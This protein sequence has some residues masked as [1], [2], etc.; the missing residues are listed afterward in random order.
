MTY[1]TRFSSILN[2]TFN[3]RTQ[4]GVVS[5]FAGVPSILKFILKSDLLAPF[6]KT[7][8]EFASRIKPAYSYDNADMLMML[9]VMYMTGM[10]DFNDA[11]EL[12]C[13][14]LIARF[15]DVP[16]DS[17][18]C[19]FFARID[20]IC[21]NDRDSRLSDADK[22]LDDC[23]KTDSLRICSAFTDKLNNVLLEGAI[24]LLKSNS[25]KHIVIDVDS[26]PVR[27]YGQQNETAFDAHYGVK[28]YL[29]IFVTINGI[30]AFV[31][32]APGAAYGAAL[33]KLHAQTIINRLNE[34]FP[35]AVVIVRADTGYAHQPLI[36]LIQDLGVR[37]IIGCNIRGGAP[38]RQETMKL[39]CD[40]FESRPKD[41]ALPKTLKKYIDAELY[42]PSTDPQAEPVRLCGMLCDYQFKS[43]KFKRNIVFRLNIDPKFDVPNLRY[44]QTNLTK[45][46]ILSFTQGRGCRKQRAL[47][48][49]LFGS[50]T[51]D[52]EF[53]IELYE[54][55]FADRGMDERMNQE[56]KAQCC[57]KRVS[58]SGF[59]A[60]TARM[61]IA[62]LVYQI[63]EKLRRFLLPTIQ[64]LTPTK[65][66]NSIKPNRT[67]PHKAEKIL[68]GPTI[69]SIRKI[70]INRACL[71][72]AKR[73]GTFTI[74][75]GH[76]PPRWRCALQTLMS[77]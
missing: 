75:T 26:T 32:N 31:Q 58:C 2:T 29:P 62:T 45:E 14:P 56:W 74:V 48:A 51:D 77:L 36:D 13:D 30:P 12:C 61:Q 10:I 66:R 60:N 34:A 15:I 7:L 24:K 28:C 59:F 37:F 39:L 27:T 73:N 19:R 42:D 21:R 23:D 76:I 9:L 64:R 25:P 68:C 20:E 1:S 3:L 4:S 67:S 33:F 43:W 69:D 72:T 71:V 35:D 5:Q 40:Y 52:I 18:L 8:D 47:S 44:V 17:T 6:R 55:A 22:S 54:A 50:H 57:A 49:D 38:L 11:D 53:A 16:S 63:F 65:R 70:L 46:E 41:G